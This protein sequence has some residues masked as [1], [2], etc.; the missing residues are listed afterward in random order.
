MEPSIYKFKTII[1]EYR[2]GKLYDTFKS[3]MCFTN[4]FEIHD[5][6]INAHDFLRSKGA[7]EITK[8]KK[9]KFVRVTVRKAPSMEFICNLPEDVE[10]S[11]K[12]LSYFEDKNTEMV[13]GYTV[14]RIPAPATSL[15]RDI[16]HFKPSTQLKSR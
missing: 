10:L 3:K 9:C 14:Q 4:I 6:L 16:L 5:T 1:S 13:I 15:K 2:N 8:N 12:E 11:V 7:T